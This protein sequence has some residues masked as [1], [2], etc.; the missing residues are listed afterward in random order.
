MR[1]GNNG[2]WIG[3]VVASAIMGVVVVWYLMD[4]RSGFA[5]HTP[6]CAPITVQTVLAVFALTGIGVALGAM[7]VRRV[8]RRWLP[9][10]LLALALHVGALSVWGYWLGKGTVLPYDKW[11][12]KVGMP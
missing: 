10:A 4:V 11:C 1:M 12:E 6:P 8:S 9:V 7:G 3:G 2:A 5:K